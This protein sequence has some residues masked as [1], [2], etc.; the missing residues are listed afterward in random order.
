MLRMNN[1]SM[2]CMTEVC[3]KAT[4]A[5]LWCLLGSVE[6]VELPGESHFGMATAWV[7]DGE[8]SCLSLS[9]AKAR[10]LCNLEPQPQKKQ[11]VNNTSNKRQ[12]GTQRDRK[13]LSNKK[14]IH[15]SFQL[16]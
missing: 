15:I 9:A 5:H 8:P 4:I 2:Q 3:N 11:H 16:I 14:E 7:A 6:D 13:P 12:Q 1:K 10:S